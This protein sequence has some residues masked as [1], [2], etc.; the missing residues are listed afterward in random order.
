MRAVNM[1]SRSSLGQTRPC[2]IET[3]A[4][5][6]RF[7]CLS[8]PAIA[9]YSDRGKICPIQGMPL[10]SVTRPSW[11]TQTLP[12][13]DVPGVAT[14]DAVLPLTLADVER[15]RILLRSLAYLE[16]L[17]K[18]WIVVPDHQQRAIEDALPRAIYDH[19]VWHPED[20]DG[21]DPARQARSR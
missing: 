13:Q 12:A 11:L 20:F 10:G 17:G 8:R 1:G 9:S 15:A 2:E 14:I 16:P 18:L 6:A 21:W 4:H 5:S 19:C 3:P 7:S